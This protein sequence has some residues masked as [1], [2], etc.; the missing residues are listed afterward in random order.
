LTLMS[1]YSLT[2]MTYPQVRAL[3]NERMRC[4]F[5]HG[6][7]RLQIC[8]SLLVIDALLI[9]GEKPES[10]YPGRVIMTNR[11]LTGRVRPS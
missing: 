10:H 1:A 4:A 5:A 2:Q 8:D 3:C 11:R 9:S 6:G 7:V